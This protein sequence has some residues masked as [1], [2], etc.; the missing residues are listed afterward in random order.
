M[1]GRYMARDN[2]MASC[3]LEEF[4]PIWV[5]LEIYG[6]G[7]QEGDYAYNKPMYPNINAFK[8]LAIGRALSSWDSEGAYT[9]RSDVSG[10]RRAP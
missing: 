8:C 1:Q 7:D 2:P 3:A 9:L 5:E 4:L 10:R 6:L